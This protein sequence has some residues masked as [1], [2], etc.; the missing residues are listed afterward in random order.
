MNKILFLFFSFCTLQTAQSQTA[1]PS[2]TETIDNTL[3]SASGIEV[4]PEFPGGIVAFYKFIRNNYKA[5]DVAGLK[6]QI[7]ISFIVERDGSL[8][9][10]KVLKDIGYGTGMEA[11]RVLS[12]SPKWKPAE[13]NGTT[14]RCSYQIPISIQLSK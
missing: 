14:V 9:E 6:G 4:K 2:A 5:P 8:S 10:I 1:V 12:L 11:I 7:Y 13:Q 3:Y